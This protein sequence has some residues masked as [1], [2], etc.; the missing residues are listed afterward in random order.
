MD[1]GNRRTVPRVT[2]NKIATVSEDEKQVHI[3][4]ILDLST[5]GACMEVGVQYEK[6]SV[7]FLH[8]DI[9]DDQSYKELVLPALV[10]WTKDVNGLVRHGLFFTDVSDMNLSRLVHLVKHLEDSQA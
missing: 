7:V 1:S 3:C 6:D 5:A 9:S 10:V 4:R 2:A 8:L